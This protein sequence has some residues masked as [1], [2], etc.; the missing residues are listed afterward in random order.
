[1]R[2]L[3]SYTVLQAVYRCRISRGF[4]RHIDEKDNGMKTRKDW[5]EWKKRVEEP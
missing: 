2:M 5:C 4:G 3:W 1:M